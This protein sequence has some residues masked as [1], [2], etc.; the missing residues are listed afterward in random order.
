MM[1]YRGNTGVEQAFPD[2]EVCYS[3][4]SCCLSSN[5]ACM[6][7]T[8]KNYQVSG[9]AITGNFSLIPVLVSTCSL[10]STCFVMKI[11][12]TTPQ[13]ETH[14]PKI[15]MFLVL[16]AKAFFTAKFCAG[17]MNVPMIITLAAALPPESS[18]VIFLDRP[19]ARKCGA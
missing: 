2:I 8:P 7:L 10:L 18:W 15:H 4:A 19:V 9:S 1:S 6:L 12:A 11:L 13:A 3:A 17:S 5:H 16:D 14:V